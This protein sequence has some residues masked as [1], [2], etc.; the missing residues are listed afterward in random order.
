M[1]AIFPG[2]RWCGDGD[3]ARSEDELGYFS[4]LDA[5]CREHDNCQYNI[6]AGES[7]ANLKN[8]GIFTKSACACDFK[9]HNCLKNVAS[10]KV[11]S[12]IQSTVA[13]QI[14]KTYFNM[15]QPQCFDC[16]C[17]AK[18]CDP[19][20]DETKCMDNQCDKYQWISNEKFI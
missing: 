11:I 19:N 3:N 20:K 9:F 16:I 1:R 14:G 4:E 10:N 6:I 15:L 8:N 7:K 18:T 13:S 5:C 2:T 12:K 17:P